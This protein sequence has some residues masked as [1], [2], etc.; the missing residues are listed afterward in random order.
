ML[1][2]WRPRKRF[3]RYYESSVG[4]TS[5][6]GKHMPLMLRSAEL[7]TFSMTNTIY[8]DLV[9]RA[10]G[11]IYIYICMY[12]ACCRFSLQACYRLL[13]VILCLWTGALDQSDSRIPSSQSGRLSV[14]HTLAAKCDFEASR[15]I[16]NEAVFSQYTYP[17]HYSIFGNID[18]SLHLHTKAFI[19]E[20]NGF[21]SGS[22][23][24][25]INR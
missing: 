23:R 16:T 22:L 5:G 20:D 9:C 12:S 4:L 25:P 21:N 3:H 24:T 6:L 15:H 17:S 13:F 2:H 7:N 18:E 11:G 19:V 8:R 14:R 1:F 10:N